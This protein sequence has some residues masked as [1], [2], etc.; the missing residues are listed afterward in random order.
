M[1]N[2]NIIKETMAN[3]WNNIKEKIS[4]LDDA[5][6]TDI[7]NKATMMQ[8]SLI[9][10][11]QE[12]QEKVMQ[13]PEQVQEQTRLK[14]LQEDKLYTTEETRQILN[15]FEI[16]TSVN[17]RPYLGQE[18]NDIITNDLLNKIKTQNSQKETI[19]NNNTNIDNSNYISSNEELDELTH[20]VSQLSNENKYNN[21]HTI[22]ILES[23][24]N[25]L[26]NVNV[27]EQSGMTFVNSLNKDGSIAYQQKIENHK[28]TGAE[29][30]QIVNTA[31]NNAD[32][33]DINISNSTNINTTQT[34]PEQN[35][36]NLNTKTTS[37]TPEKVKSIVEPFS[38]QQEYTIEEMA[39][40]MK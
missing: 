39:N 37:Y 30:K 18:L 12:I 25:K 31:I 17:N 7:N 8:L 33:S 3:T 16:D 6:I 40:I 15:D 5:T 1:V 27:V 35:I 11:F 14:F 20:M 9:D 21:A 34:S 38:S 22:G 29:I 24:S 2:M 36:D 10:K 13:E 4:N 23:V 19:N 28:Y 26:K 32:L